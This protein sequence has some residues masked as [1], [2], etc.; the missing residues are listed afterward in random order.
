MTTRSGRDQW[1]L[2]LKASLLG[3][4]V[5]IPVAD[6]RLVL[7]TWQGLYLCEHRNH[8]G[9]RRVVVTIHGEIKDG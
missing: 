8:G 6:G 1:I 7:G 2:E 3:F 4:S 9:L 5:S